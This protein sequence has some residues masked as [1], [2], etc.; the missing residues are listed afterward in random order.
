MG[1]VAVDL[2]DR[3]HLDLLTTNFAG[4]KNSYYRFLAAGG[5]ASG[6]DSWRFE[7]QSSRIGFDGHRSELGWGIVAGDF[8][9]DGRRDIFVANGQIY[10]QVDALGGVDG[11]GDEQ[12]RY[13][14]LPRVYLGDLGDLGDA[15]TSDGG[16]PRLRE[17]A[18]E[19][20]F[21][22]STAAGACR[23]TACL[24]FSLRAAAVGDLD[25]DGD[26]DIVAIQHNGPLVLFEN[27]SQRPAPMVALE[28]RDGG[29]SPHG[30]RIEIP[31]VA[32]TRDWLYHHWPTSGYQSSHDPRVQLPRSP[33]AIARVSW[34]HGSCEEFLV[35]SAGETVVWREGTGTGRCGAAVAD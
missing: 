22:R 12:D 24:A 25:N 2:F 8:D 14:Q 23:G 32:E 19:Q 6:L 28:S 34:P 16:E 3:G 21:Q 4:E 18:P 11:V 13:R 26:L 5:P 27:R 31:G 30:A 1:V 7:D 17:A 20:V 15:G 10:P 9:G 33:G 29:A 35:P